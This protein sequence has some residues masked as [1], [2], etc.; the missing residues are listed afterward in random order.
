[1]LHYQQTKSASTEDKELATES[2]AMSKEYCVWVVPPKNGRVRKVHFSWK[3]ILCSVVALSAVISVL[4]LLAG[5]YVRVQALRASNYVNAKRMASQLE[6]FKSENES[7]STKVQ[8]LSSAQQRVEQ[9]ESQIRKKVDQLATI[10]EGATNIGIVDSN[11]LA[12]IAEKNPERSSKRKSITRAKGGLGGLELDCSNSQSQSCVDSISEAR[13]S[14]RLDTDQLWK[15]RRISN[16]MLV[17]KLNSYIDVTK[18]IP[19]GYPVSG[20]INSGFGFRRSP[21]SGKIKMHQGVDFSLPR[22]SYIF[23]TAF[24]KVAKVERNRTYGL[25]V[26]LDHGSGILT[27]YAHLS[28]ALVKVGQQVDRGDIVGHVGSTGHSTGPHL[29]YEVRF[30]GKAKNPNRFMDLAYKL[31]SVMHP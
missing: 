11:K 20:E 27:R 17:S 30:H 29:H 24:G 2:L 12:V 13:A 9:Y 16:E 10:L 21:F 7:L 19:L 6:S 23:S 1:V 28:R 8:T 3:H 26:D 22:G 18:A 31:K 25:M 4:F 5:D 14:L 15:G